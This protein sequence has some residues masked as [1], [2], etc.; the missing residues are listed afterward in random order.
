MNFW[1]QKL[2]WTYYQHL[3]YGITAH[4]NHSFLLTSALRNKDM[5]R[6]TIGPG[7]IEIMTLYKFMMDSWSRIDDS[8]LY[9]GVMIQHANLISILDCEFL[10]SKLVF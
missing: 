3:E 6:D 5:R 8:T 7:L 2:T 1:S 9:V 4:F 10:I